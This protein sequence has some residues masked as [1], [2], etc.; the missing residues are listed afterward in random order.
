MVYMMSVHGRRSDLVM[1]DFLVPHDILKAVGWRRV[2]LS[3][4]CQVI[5]AKISEFIC[6][7]HFASKFKFTG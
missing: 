7:L 2:E 5:T 3:F 4:V 1:Y 6:F